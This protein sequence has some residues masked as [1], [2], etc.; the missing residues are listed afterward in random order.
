MILIWSFKQNNKYIE[1][2]VHMQHWNNSN[3]IGCY[4]LVDKSIK[5]LELEIEFNYE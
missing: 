5:E 3:L 4:I 1:D 2:N